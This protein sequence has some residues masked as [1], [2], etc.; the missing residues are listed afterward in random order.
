MRYA[1]DDMEASV[2]ESESL[3]IPARGKETYTGEYKTA[4]VWKVTKK[5]E[6]NFTAKKVSMHQG[7][8]MEK[9]GKGRENLYVLV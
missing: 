5:I 9:G 2:S 6:L 3:A 7:I 1:D 4:A 8:S